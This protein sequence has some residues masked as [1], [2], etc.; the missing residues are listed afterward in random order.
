MSPGSK[1]NNT[2]ALLQ[3]L[4]LKYLSIPDSSKQATVKPFIFFLWAVPLYTPQLEGPT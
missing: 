3:K 4:D 2:V 1:R